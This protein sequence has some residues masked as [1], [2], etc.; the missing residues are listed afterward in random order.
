MNKK[1]CD[2]DKYEYI[3]K[4]IE[5]FNKNKGMY[6]LRTIIKLLLKHI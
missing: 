4:C 6:L 1:E 2:V 3:H 5:L